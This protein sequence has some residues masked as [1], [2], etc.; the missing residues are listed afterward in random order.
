MNVK[1]SRDLLQSQENSVKVQFYF[2]NMKHETFNTPSVNKQQ[3]RKSRYLF[4][5]ENILKL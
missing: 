2:S 3:Y 4:F 5:E 1:A